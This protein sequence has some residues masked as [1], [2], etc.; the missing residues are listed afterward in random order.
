[1]INQEITI[2]VKGGIAEVV[3]AEN[4]LQTTII[5]II[6]SDNQPAT[7]EEMKFPE[8]QEEIE[9]QKNFLKLEMDNKYPTKN[10]LF[11]TYS[12]GETYFNLFDD[13]GEIIGD[14]SESNNLQVLGIAQGET[15]E[16]AFEQL[17][18]DSRHIKDSIE[19]GYITDMQA[20]KILADQACIPRS[21]INSLKKGK[22][23]A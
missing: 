12:E 6:D 13:N 20:Y 18:K 3:S 9:Q 14:S 10:Y 7:V 23:N 19:D 11:I 16:Q 1:M 15:L 2:E 8:G 22:N 17:L 21:L 4:T 5:K